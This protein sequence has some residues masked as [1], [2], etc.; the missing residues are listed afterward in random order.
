MSQLK[1]NTIRHTGASSDA[2]TLANDGKCAITGSTITADTGKFTNLPNRNLV[3][4]G[5]MKVAQRGTSVTD[6]GYQTVDRFQ[7]GYGG[8][9]NHLTQAQHALTS[10]DT[11][12]WE[13]GFR[14]SYHIT[15]G[16]QTGGAGATDFAQ[17]LYR[18]EG[19]DIHGSG[20]NF[21][22]P[23]SKVTISYWVK[24]SVA[25]NYY[26]FIEAGSPVRIFGW[27]TGALTANTWKKVT[28]TIPG[29]ASLAIPNTN[30][31]AFVMAF[32]PHY[33]TGYTH[34]S[35]RTVGSWYEAYNYIPDMATTWWTTDDATFEITGVQLEAGSVATD[36]EH[37]SYGDELA[38]CQRYYQQYD[39][40]SNT[41][42]YVW[43]IA[44]GGG[45]NSAGLVIYYPTIMRALPTGSGE[46][47]NNLNFNDGSTAYTAANNTYSFAAYEYVVKISSSSLGSMT[48][49]AIQVY[50]HGS[51][52]NTKIKL[53]AEL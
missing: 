37:R 35:N 13:K 32:I 3:I 19:Q 45:S 42:T 23:N 10:S 7:L 28:V 48:G 2:I 33:G 51:V 44:F 34:A 38:R 25:Q 22:D 21:T 5:A 43:G 30:A 20:W 15:N 4:N 11:G 18:P 14:Y 29:Y 47:L 24:S 50:S 9:D 31:S 39:D 53:D 26:G 8:T 41:G 17:I 6:D 27:E 52:T 40:S 1:V 49:K 12:P 16:N 46:N 36:F